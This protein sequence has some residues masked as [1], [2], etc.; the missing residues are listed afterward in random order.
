M[1]S[2]AILPAARSRD[3]LAESKSQATPRHS[4]F[5][6]ENSPF[7]LLSRVSGRYVQVLDRTLKDIGTDVPGWRTLMIVHENEP[8][9]VSE[10]AERAAIRLSTMTRVVQRLEGN[11]LV[12]LRTRASDARITDVYLSAKGRRQLAR[13]RTAVGPIVDTAL[14]DLDGAEIQALN[15]MLRRI[16]VNL[17]GC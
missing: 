13:I 6:L 11:D 16:F 7:Y 3:S 10:I 8:S 12:R 17:S 5:R 2:Q 15:D 1:K 14:A 9:S 4:G